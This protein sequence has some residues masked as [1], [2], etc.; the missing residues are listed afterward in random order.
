MA[1]FS[2]RVPF[3]TKQELSEDQLRHPPYGSNLTFPLPRY[4]RFSQTSGTSGNPVR[5]LDTAG[6]GAWMLGNWDCV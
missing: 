4:S 5:W 2:R 6:T 3:T 1:T